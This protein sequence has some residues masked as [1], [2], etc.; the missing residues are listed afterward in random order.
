MCIIWLYSLVSYVSE[1][2]SQRTVHVRKITYDENNKKFVMNESFDISRS[3]DNYYISCVQTENLIIVCQ[4]VK[5]DCKEFGFSF[6]VDGTNEK[7]FH[8]FNP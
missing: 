7:D 4:Y 3:T 6:N 2:D 5:K 1:K 8:I